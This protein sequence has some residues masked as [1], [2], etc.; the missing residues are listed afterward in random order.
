M[1]GGPEVRDRDRPADGPGVGVATVTFPEGAQRS[2]SE[3]EDRS[4]NQETDHHT[5][6]VRVDSTRP[7]VG[8]HSDQGTNRYLRGISPASP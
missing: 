3:G 5:A 8:D 6:S 4:G 7:T 1:D 2:S